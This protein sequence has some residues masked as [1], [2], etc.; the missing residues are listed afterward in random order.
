MKAETYD[1]ASAILKRMARL[2]SKALVYSSPF[3][4]MVSDGVITQEQ[5]DRWLSE[6]S[7]SD[8]EELGRLK[9]EFEAL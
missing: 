5:A 7:A 4:E 1:K 9:N 8:K 2:N 6:I 3:S